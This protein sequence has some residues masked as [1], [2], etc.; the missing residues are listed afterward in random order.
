MGM[1][2]GKSTT[3]YHNDEQR[4]QAVTSRDPAADGTFYYAVVTTGIYCRPSCAAR[5][6]RR[7]NV[8]F[9]DS[10][11][12]AESAGFRPC[13]RCHPKGPSLRERQSALIT[14]ACHQIQ[15]SQPQ[16][17]LQALAD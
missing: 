14:A 2:A 1:A 10:C 9:H 16:P 17:S 4:W 11:A 3:K 6:A 12:A 15:A 5:P 13:K 7:E 8:C